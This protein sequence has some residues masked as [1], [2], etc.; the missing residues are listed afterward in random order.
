MAKVYDAIIVGA[1]PAG[2]FCSLKLAER[3]FKVLLL[4]KGKPLEKR[5]CP[6]P[7][8]R[9][10]FCSSCSITSGWGGAGAF[11]DGKLTFSSEIGGWLKTFFPRRELNWAIEEAIQA[12][13]DFGA[14]P[15]RIFGEESEEVE[16]LKR[17][18]VQAELV[19]VP[20]KIKHLGTENCF[21]VLE[22]IHRHL[23]E[24]IDLLFET[25]VK[26]IL[27]KENRVQGVVTNRGTYRGK[28]VVLAPGRIGADWLR[29][30]AIRLGF[31]LSQN[32]VDIGVRVEVPAPILEPLTKPL[33][34][35]K[36]L[37]FSRPF[38]D[39]VR[40]FC[41]NPYGEVIREVYEDVITVNGHSYAR[42]KTENSNFAILVSTNFTHPFKEPIAYGK[43]IAR[44]ANLLGEGIIIQRL[45]DLI[46]GRRS[47]WE[48]VNRSLVKP[49]LTAVTPGDLSFVFPY[50][51]LVDVLEM[52]KALDKL[53][54]GV[55]SSHT[56]L[57][58]VEVK[59]YSSRLKLKKNLETE[60]GGLFAAGDGAGITRGLAQAAASGILVAWSVVNKLK[61]KGD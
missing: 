6:S 33:Y 48:R 32:N 18:A 8:G 17:R 56:L 4:E 24:K 1:G 41:M 61:L 34:E 26:E 21:R 51:Y 39:R 44:L 2:I 31:T 36:L 57:Y 12:F 38:E 37:Y 16:E 42:R 45:G 3:N 11:S 15:G 7:Q 13:S 59:F 28:T 43:Y 23:K 55:Y 27:V 9:C 30:E 10:L 19:L 58:G 25:E 22:A 54:P 50:R 5:V 29:K 47:T 49:S 46:Q 20:T 53:A 40:T 60:V 52:L 35:A 14:P